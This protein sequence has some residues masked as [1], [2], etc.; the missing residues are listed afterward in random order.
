VAALPFETWF[1]KSEQD[2]EVT[3]YQVSNSYPR[4]C[5]LVCL[6]FYDKLL[7][8]LFFFVILKNVRK[9]AELFV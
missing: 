9:R 4:S 1:W 8:L 2:R 3:K 7:R 6:L 5:F